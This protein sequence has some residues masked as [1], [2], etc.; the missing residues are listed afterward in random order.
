MSNERGTQGRCIRLDA[1]CDKTEKG[2][3]S[4]QVV[5]WMGCMPAQLKA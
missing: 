2:E 1:A 5:A 4:R 3:V